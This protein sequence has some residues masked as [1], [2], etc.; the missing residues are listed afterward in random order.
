MELITK[1]D[2]PTSDF[3]IDY[4]TNLVFIGSCF[5]DNI[6]RKWASRKFHVLANPL[7][8][9]YNPLSIENFIEK[10]SGTNTEPW[11]RWDYQGN[12]SG[13]ELEGIVHS[14][15][16]F[17][18]K[19][20]VV[21]IT[22]G[23]AFVYFLKETGKAVANCHKEPADLFERRLI[24]VD[25][26]A[27]AL[28]N[29]VKCILKARL[30]SRFCE[31]DDAGNQNDE[32][33]ISRDVKIVFTVS[34]IRHL[35]DGAHGNNLS[36]ATL[37]LAVEKVCQEFANAPLLD[38]QNVSA[39]RCCAAVTHFPSYEIVM[40]ELRDYRF[41]ADDMTHIGAIAE[42]YIFERMCETYCSSETIADM[43][44]VEKFMK[45]ATHRIE[46]ASSPRTKDFAKLQIER[47]ENLE[48]VISGLD[49]SEE[50]EYFRK[51]I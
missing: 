9:I 13:E 47:A 51:F 33:N 22:L 4:K 46:D 30:D 12:F 2:I 48:H 39:G 18:A 34:P 7:G 38:G 36:K 41:Y 29:I 42:D 27:E 20:D 6:S 25:E 21:F 35:N 45:G 31:N 50:K 14:S 5:A 19:A 44:H 37:Q 15:R 16:K 10:L 1:A 43:K 32:K 23:T 17:F 26:A 49:L 28:R 3:K 40:D 24:S 11:N 8:V